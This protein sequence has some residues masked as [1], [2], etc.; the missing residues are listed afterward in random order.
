MKSD[1][2]R[3]LLTNCKTL[4]QT[5]LVLA[6]IASLSS[7]ADVYVSSS[8][9]DSNPGTISSPVA[10]I[11]KAKSLASGI[12]SKESVTVH[13]ADGTYYLPETIVFT[14]ADSG[15]VEHPVVYR[16]ENEGGVVVSGGSQLRLQWQAYRNGI[17]MAKTEPGLRIDQFFVD[18]KNQRM[19]RYPNYDADKK[20]DAYQ[21]FAADAFDKG[22]AAKWANPAG[23][24][25]HAMHKARWGG[26]HYRITGKEANGDVTYEGGWQNNRQMGMHNEFRMVE[27]IFEELDAP[28]EWFQDAST[29]TLYYKPSDGVDLP[30]AKVEVV[31]LRHLI[32]FQGSESKPVKHVTLRGFIFRHSAR[33][34]MD[35]KEQLLRSDWAIYRGGTI[36]LTGT[37]DVQILDSEFD[38]VGGNAIFASNYNRR[39]LVKGCH[40]HD[41]G[42]SGVCF[43]GNP[44]AVRDPL[45]EYNQK[46][47][48][49]RICRR[50]IRQRTSCK[51]G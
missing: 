32:E 37:E 3:V 47:D 39:V 2:Q 21:G 11:T 42:A 1:S 14:P 23:G 20:T 51:V 15:T 43:V 44:D 26:Y 17:M 4:C 27:N 35:T 40:I 31:R 33:T 18:G 24:Y 41:A 46:N 10:S 7:A 9:K 12:V 49:S 13:V 36:L 30:S 5:L 19:A 48:L 22:R 29:S 6:S 34:F 8:G 28:G 45:F 25:I 50:C 16:A 38:Q